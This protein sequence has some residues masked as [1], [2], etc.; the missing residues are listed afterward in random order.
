MLSEKS[1]ATCW[2][3]EGRVGIVFK[4]PERSR[5]LAQ[6]SWNRLMIHTCCLLGLSMV[7]G[8]AGLESLLVCLVL[9]RRRGPLGCW[10]PLDKAARPSPVTFC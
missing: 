8:A 5:E 10:S 6:R 9:V 7:G 4:D 2:F 3:G 1:P